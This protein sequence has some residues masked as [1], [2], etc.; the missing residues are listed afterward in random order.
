M[1]HTPP[2]EAIDDSPA[3][4]VHI[5]KQWVS[6]VMGLL[7]PLVKT[8]F[9]SGD[10]ETVYDAQQEGEKLMLALAL[11]SEVC[12]VPIGSIMAWPVVASPVSAPENWLFCD[13]SPAVIEDYP[14]LFALIGTT[15]GSPTP[16]YSFGLPDLRG[17]FLLGAGTGFAL[18]STGGAATVALTTAQLPAHSHGISTRVSAT[19]GTG[20]RLMRASGAETEVTQTAQTGSGQAHQNMPPYLTLNYIIRAK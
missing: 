19:S 11:G 14:E 15:F 8:W 18:A 13:G 20:E 16:G 17:R 2:V 9:W 4:C 6:W 3:V 7:E 5:N 10:D 1:T 12:M